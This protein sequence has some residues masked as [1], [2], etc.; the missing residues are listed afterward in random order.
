MEGER[1]GVSW[2]ESGIERLVFFLHIGKLTAAFMLMGITSRE[3][4]HD[5]AGEKGDSWQEGHLSAGR[6][7]WH[8]VYS[9]RFWFLFLFFI[10]V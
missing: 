9:G 10:N 3:E 4:K 5:Y 2:W 7:G 8:L 6:R 1:E